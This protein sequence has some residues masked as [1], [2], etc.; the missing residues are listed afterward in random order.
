MRANRATVIGAFV[1]GGIGVAVAAILF[2]GTFH[3]FTHTARA[4]VFFE[5]SIGGLSPGAPV[6]FRGV[7]IGSVAST[8]LIVDRSDLKTQIPVYLEIDPERVTLTGLPAGPQSAPSL[9]R[10][11][12]AGLRAQLTMQSLVTGQMQVELDLRPDTPARLIGAGPA[13][14]PELPA[15]PSD[16]EELRQ[17]LVRTPIAETVAQAGRTL[18]AV[19][20]L[21]NR[22]DAELDP[23]AASAQRTLDSAT[24]TLVT[25]GA[26]IQHLQEDAMAT[27]EEVR[28][29]AN[30]GHR[31]LDNRSRELS[32]VLLSADQ[33]L[34]SANTFLDSADSLVARRSPARTNLEAALRDLADTARALRGFS[35]TVERNPNALLLGRLGQ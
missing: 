26:S 24:H 13:D 19:E 30:D 14:V 9:Q 11:V 3:L 18:V 8:A 33:A 22:I 31:Q 15:I 6:A 21:A 23:L 28:A 12:E 4:V 7:R 10:L 5:G 35:Q 2:F 29:L 27:L 20:K 1:L 34:H 17:Q 32:R 16:F 25:A